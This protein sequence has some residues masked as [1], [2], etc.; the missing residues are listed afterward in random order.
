MSHADCLEHTH[1]GMTSDSAPHGTAGHTHHSGC[2]VCQTCSATPL[3]L[4]TTVPRLP[5]APHSVPRDAG[6]RFASAE[7]ARGFKPPIS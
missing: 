4:Q 7:P 2:T 6:A 5:L 1:G 3:A